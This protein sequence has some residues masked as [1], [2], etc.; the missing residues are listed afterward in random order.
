[1]KDQFYLIIWSNDVTGNMFN[2]PAYTQDSAIN[3]VE[4]IFRSERSI[5]AQRAHM[6]AATAVKVTECWIS[7]REI[8]LQ[9][10]LVESEAGI[11]S[12]IPE[13]LF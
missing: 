8:T 10:K 9:V 7:Y 11:D 12:F 5:P 2:K 3:E 4:M 13:R 1:M 6:I